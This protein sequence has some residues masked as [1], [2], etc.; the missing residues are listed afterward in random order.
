MAAC[1]DPTK[2]WFGID[3]LT[4]RPPPIPVQYCECCGF[5]DDEWMGVLALP[6]FVKSECRLW[7]FTVCADCQTLPGAYLRASADVY[8]S[9]LLGR[10]VT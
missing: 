3:F 6:V 9:I 10:C 1:A 5:L 8:F 2:P 4:W 7:P